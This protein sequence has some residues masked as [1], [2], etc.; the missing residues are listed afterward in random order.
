MILPVFTKRF[1]RQDNEAIL[2]AVV[3]GVA[4]LLLVLVYG[5]NVFPQQV[6]GGLAISAK[7]RHADGILVGSDVRLSG[8][9]VGK[10]IAT[11]LD[12]QF[13][14]VTTLRLRPGLDIPVDTA[15]AI[16]SDSLLGAK[17]IELKLGGDDEMMKQ[18]G[19][20]SYTQD[21][22]TFEKLMDMILSQARARRG[23]VGKTL[24]KV[25]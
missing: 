6:K 22:L 8:V 25:L 2:G 20:L 10:V 5:H 21:S 24:P 17:Y 3:L 19:E 14:A 18:G 16:E 7:F 23:Y 12:N 9:V 13:R 4:A 11:T 15:A 1:N